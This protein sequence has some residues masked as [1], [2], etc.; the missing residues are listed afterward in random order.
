[1]P[2]ADTAAEPAAEQL[3]DAEASYP[4]EEV[5]VKAART[6]TAPICLGFSD[7][8]S[9]TADESNPDNCDWNVSPILEREAA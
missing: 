6:N 5:L 8:V 2:A 3:T 1:M 9:D 7:A 4:C